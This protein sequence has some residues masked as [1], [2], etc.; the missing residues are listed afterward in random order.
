MIRSGAPVAQ[1]IEIQEMWKRNNFTEGRDT[2]CDYRILES[3]FNTALFPHAGFITAVVVLVPSFPISAGLYDTV[4]ER[5][6]FAPILV[7]FT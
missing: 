6:A 4:L 7:Y 3:C 5:C 1:H 2:Q